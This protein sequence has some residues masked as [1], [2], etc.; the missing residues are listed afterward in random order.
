MREQLGAI[1][2]K[3]EK[4]PFTSKA[5]GE[6]LQ[7]VKDA[8]AEFRKEAGTVQTSIVQLDIKI[9]KWQGLPMGAKDLVKNLRNQSK[10][11]GAEIQVLPLV[12][13]VWSSLPHVIL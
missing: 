5:M 6:D 2:D 4:E 3:L 7:K 10:F 1:A 11:R 13:S 8:T 9:G 12:L